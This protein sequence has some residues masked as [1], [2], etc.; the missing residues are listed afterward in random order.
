MLKKERLDVER[1]YIL[2]TLRGLTASKSLL[3]P[4]W[5][6]IAVCDWIDRDGLLEGPPVEM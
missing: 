5:N 1:L 4:V 6:Q 2:P 3:A